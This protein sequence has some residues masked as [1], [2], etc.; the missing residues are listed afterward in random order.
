MLAVA[1]FPQVNSENLIL[2]QLEQ[3]I[4][5]IAVRIRATYRRRRLDRERVLVNIK[6]EQSL[7]AGI[8]RTRDHVHFKIRG[9][10]NSDCLDA[11]QLF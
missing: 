5:L 11:E 6:A 3:T 9:V 7:V 8:V 1:K 10:L 2:G 4:R